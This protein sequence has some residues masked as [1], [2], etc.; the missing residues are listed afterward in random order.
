MPFHPDWLPGVLGLAVFRRARDV[1]I[2]HREGR[3]ELVEKTANPAGVLVRKVTLV[4]QTGH[5]ARVVGM[6]LEDADG[7]VILSSSIVAFHRDGATG[8]DFPSRVKLQ[9]PDSKV[10]IVVHIHLLERVE[11]KQRNAAVF[12]APA[13]K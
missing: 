4:E 3:V 7:A 11:A 9:W 2:V 8:R 5:G 12:A 13:G 6:R 10:E 1:T